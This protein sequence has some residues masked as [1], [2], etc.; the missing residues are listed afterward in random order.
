[1]K[2]HVMVGM[3]KFQILNFFKLN[4]FAVNFQ[5]NCFKPSKNLETTTENNCQ[6]KEIKHGIL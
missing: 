6:P 2:E 4:I 3:K 1:M 5:V